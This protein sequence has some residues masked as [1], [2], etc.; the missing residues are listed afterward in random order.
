MRDDDE[1]TPACIELPQ[2]GGNQSRP[3]CGI[4]TCRR[5]IEKENVCFCG[6]G[7]RRKQTAAL[8]AREASGIRPQWLIQSRRKCPYDIGELRRLKRAEDAL[9]TDPLVQAREIIADRRAEEIAA[10]ERR[11]E[12]GTCLRKRERV[13]RNAAIADCPAV[14]LP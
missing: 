13:C 14:A 1:C 12:E 8:S 10:L 2:Y 5:F 11:A 3:A 9:L 6:K 7:K 4:Q